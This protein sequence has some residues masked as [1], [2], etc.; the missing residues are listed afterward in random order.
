MRTLL[1]Y[2][3]SELRRVPFR[4]LCELAQQP[5]QVIRK[6][7]SSSYTLVP[8]QNAMVHGRF[9]KSIC[10]LYSS[11]SGKCFNSL[12][13]SN[14]RYGYQPFLLICT[15]SPN[16]QATFFRSPPIRLQGLI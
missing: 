3:L 12:D 4:D 11:T 13:V 15:L 8:S 6:D 9:G 2:P 1:E 10:N 5:I 16:L 14:R 7:D